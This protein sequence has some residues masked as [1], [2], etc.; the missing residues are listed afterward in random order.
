[1]T[2]TRHE[3]LTRLHALLQPRSYFEIGVSRGLSLTL[4]RTR[5]VAVDPFFEINRE[6][7]CDLH[8]VRASSDEFF[9]RR[10][11]FAH[12]DEPVVDL[13]FIDGMH[14]AEY[15]L[16]DVINTERYTRSTSVVVIDDMLP[17]N[18][19]EAS[20]AHPGPGAR[21]WAGDVY[22][23]IRA[24]RTFRPDLVCLP[25]DTRPTGTVVLLAPDPGSTVL[26]E[27]YD[28][29]VEQL[30]TP[31]PQ[32][33][34]DDILHRVGAVDPE[35][36]LEAPIWADLRRLRSVPDAVARPRVLDLVRAAGLLGSEP[37]PS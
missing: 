13:A 21:A 25:V 37:V 1:M 35:R 7:L 9:A 11:P 26:A 12:L 8:L 29:L 19:A 15:A 2:I 4:S 16:R 36:L 6:V 10:H 23:M 31:D 33:V 27:E 28:G 22:K 18:V 30:V 34:P 3:L 20:R 5:T 32:A 24:F 17:R 14:L